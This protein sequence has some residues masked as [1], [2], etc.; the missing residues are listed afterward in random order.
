MTQR[1][2]IAS[3][4]LSGSAR[5]FGVVAKAEY[6]IVKIEKLLVQLRALLTN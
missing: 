6:G 3:V 1:G 4:I 2:T 5:N